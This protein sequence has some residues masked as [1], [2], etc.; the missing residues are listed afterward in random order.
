MRRLLNLTISLNSFAL[1]SLL[2]LLLLL[3]PML[4]AARY[5]VPS[6]DDYGPKLPILALF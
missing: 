6:A 5:D 2:A 1:F 4:N 3:V